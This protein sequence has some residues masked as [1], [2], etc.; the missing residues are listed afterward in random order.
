MAWLEDDGNEL[1]TVQ[2]WVDGDTL[3][4]SNGERIRLI[5]IDAPEMGTCMGED[6]RTLAET[7]APPGWE[8]ILLDPDS[9][10]DSDKYDR[11]LRYVITGVQDSATDVGYHLIASDLADARYDSRDGYDPHP[12]EDSYR[13]ADGPNDDSACRERDRDDNGRDDDEEDREE[14]RKRLEAL[15]RRDIDQNGVVDEEERAYAEYWAAKDEYGAGSPEADAAWERYQDAKPQVSG[16]SG[17]TF[18]VPGSLC[19][20]RWC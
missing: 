7:L 3:V 5:G 17:G 13:A 12:W 20:T 19:P 16:G 4:T 14:E 18:N 9:V 1:V 2:R 15:D 8:V 10:D 11:S 6:A